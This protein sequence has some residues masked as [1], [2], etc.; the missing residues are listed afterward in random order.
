MRKLSWLLIATLITFYTAHLWSTADPTAT[1]MV[2]DGLLLA[3]VAIVIVARFAFIDANSILPRHS[4]REQLT[5]MGSILLGTGAI[6]ALVGALLPLLLTAPV[7]MNTALLLRGLG[8]LLLAI[9][10]GWPRAWQ[11]V[12]QRQP[13][14]VEADSF[15]PSAPAIRAPRPV[16]TGLILLL[17]TLFG[18]AVR[19]LVLS[20]LPNFCMASECDLALAL[21]GSLSASAPTLW[22]PQLLFRLTA[23]SLQSVRLGAGLLAVLIVPSFYL[24][25]RRLT[26]NG[27]ALL[28]SLLLILAPWFNTLGGSTLSLLLLLFWISAALW[29]LWES[30][31]RQQPRWAL[32]AGAAFGLTSSDMIVQTTLLFWLL[33]LVL[34]MLFPRSRHHLAAALLAL[35]GFL[36]VSPPLSMLSAAGISTLETAAA[37]AFTGTS[38]LFTLF[39]TGLLTS[40]EWAGVPLLAMPLGALALLGVGIYLRRI[41]DARYLWLAG[42]LLLF[43]LLSLYT[44]SNESMALLFLLALVTA[45][46]TLSTLLQAFYTNWRPLIPLANSVAVAALIVLVLAIGPLFTMLQQG[47]NNR[48]LDQIALEERMTESV[49]ALLEAKPDRRIFAPASLIESPGTRL[50]L[51]DEALAHLQP[52]ADLVNSLY[53]TDAVAETVYLIPSDAQA[54][55][56]LLTRIQPGALFDQQIDPTTGALQFTIV[57]VTQAEQLARQGLLGVAWE[58]SESGNSTPMS[59]PA[60]DS[61]MALGSDLILQPPY[62]VQWSGALRVATPG[63]Y[64]ILLDPAMTNETQPLITL[65]LDG[66]LILD[67]SLDLLAQEVTL[68]KGFYQVAL[69]YRS[70]LAA[71]EAAGPTNPLP[72]AVRWQRPDG[73]DEVIPRSVLYNLPLPNLGL[74]GEYYWGETAQGEPFDTRKDLVVGLAAE[75]SEPYTIRWYG[76]LAAPRDGEYLLAALSA[77]Q[78]QSQLYVDGLQLFDTTL[79]EPTVADNDNTPAESSIYA[80]GSIYL[81]RG[82]HEITIHYRPNPA[83]PNMTL[84]W[85]PPGSSPTPLDL[86]YLAPIATP[87][88]EHDRPLPVAPPLANGTEDAPFALSVGTE[89]WQPQSQV[90]PGVLPIQSLESVWQIGSCGSSDLQLAQPHGVAISTVRGLIYVADS[91]NRRVVE[92]TLSG[93][94]NRIYTSDDWQEPFAIALIDDGFPVLLDAST[95]LLY[96]L[97]TVTGA[98]TPRPLR[99]SFYHPRGLAVDRNGNLLVADTGGG[100]VVVLSPAG[101]E[102]RTIGGQ[103]TQIGRGQ[104]TAVADGNG[105]LWGVT[106]EDG[107]LW[108]MDSGSSLSAI[109]KTNTI[110]GPHLAALPNGTLFLSDPARRLI[111]YTAATGE[112]LAHLILP[113]IELPTGIAVTT[114]EDLLYLAVVDS[115]S[116]QLSLWRTPLAQLPSP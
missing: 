109:E 19:L 70:P 75:R 59:L 43:S 18:F 86:T 96:D 89:F 29:L 26:T 42:G 1:Y 22:L 104:P 32:L 82:W 88:Q 45:T 33:L 8:F 99:A 51:G 13:E 6:C 37:G 21:D 97:N 23:E 98:V 60:T 116:C 67:S 69:L 28:G 53:T 110:N 27:A 114:I 56:D 95:Q 4:L 115:Q 61:L 12:R 64:R 3:V 77:P 112:P 52:L 7:A 49:A 93:E 68:V 62:T 36:V 66:R 74:I 47:Q 46:L 14:Q 102:L 92:Y 58:S 111:L 25:L 113:T 20:R 35:V 100:R 108:Q 9:G 94:V 5:A 85:Q 10:I 83:E 72:F 31:S 50:R 55:A 30:L 106:A 80:E 65:Q 48:S 87:L 34:V 2:R 54:Y 57:T 63:T 15:S 84:F 11:M 17:V 101:E 38:W 39:Q 103:G 73:V 105:I 79:L 40:T 16:A 44:G 107:R 24:F 91:A 76:Q 78:S 41:T 81:T 71:T 90:P